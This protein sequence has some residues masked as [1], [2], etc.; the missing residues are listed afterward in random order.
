MRPRFCQIRSAG[1]GKSRKEIQSSLGKW[2][3]RRKSKTYYLKGIRNGRG[4]DVVRSRHKEHGTWNKCQVSKE[5][6]TYDHP[7]DGNAPSR[8]KKWAI[9]CYEDLAYK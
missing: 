8:G 2:S 6:V 4:Q 3:L 9:N 7:L 5:A 1:S